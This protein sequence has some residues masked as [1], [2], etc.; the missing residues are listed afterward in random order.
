LAIGVFACAAAV[1]ACQSSK[2]TLSCTSVA[3][4]EELCASQHCDTTWAAVEADHTY[5]DTCALGAS[6]VAVLDCGDYHVLSAFSV[7]SGSTFYYR[8][9]T[10]ALVAVQSGGA[11]NI[12][13]TC[14]AVGA[15]S[16]SPPT[17]PTAALS[18]V[19]SWC[20]PDAGAPGDRVFPCCSDTIANC[21][22]GTLCPATWADAQAQALSLCGSDIRGTNPEL[23]SCGGD[24]VFR[25]QSYGTMPLTAYY[26]ASGA[27]IAVIDETAGTCRYGGTGGLTLPACDATLTSAC[28]D[29]GAAP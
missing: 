23:G 4:A 28:P 8:R 7:D 22:A 9:D 5:C 11:P 24:N 18:R 19:P 14:Y 27:L 26:D 25:Y 3:S 16:F 20:G 6:Y 15:V 17:C 29:G 10:G 12:T 1:T 2:A 21:P 13:D